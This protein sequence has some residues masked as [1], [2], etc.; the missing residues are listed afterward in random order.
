MCVLI[1]CGIE[2]LVVCMNTYGKYK[3]INKNY[4]I[5]ENN[6]IGYKIFTQVQLCHQCQ[7]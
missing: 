5:V 4:I 6:G 3:G 7:N 2:G 1:K